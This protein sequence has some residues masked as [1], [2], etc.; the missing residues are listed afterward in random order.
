MVHI[1]FK[2]SFDSIM[3][4]F[5]TYLKT[6]T[7]TSVF[8]CLNILNHI[9]SLDVSNEELYE[10]AFPTNY[11]I[12]CLIERFG[13][14][15]SANEAVTPKEEYNQ[16][17]PLALAKIKSAKGNLQTESDQISDLLQYC[18]IDTQNAKYMQLFESRRYRQPNIIAKNMVR[19]LQ[20][21]RIVNGR[22]KYLCKF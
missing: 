7:S 4:D 6:H 11:M 22:V 8:D 20:F 14:V 21:I 1:A 15:V 10:K 16:Q 18:S 17:H 5:R 19:S 13:K 9:Q 3:K 12:Y 2:S